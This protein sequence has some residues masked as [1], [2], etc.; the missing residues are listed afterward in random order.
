M[1]VSLKSESGFFFLRVL[2]VCI[3]DSAIDQVG[4]VKVLLV[5]GRC[6][7]DVADKLFL[8]SKGSNC[9]VTSDKILLDVTNV[10]MVKY[11]KP[12]PVGI[13]EPL[14]TDIS[15]VMQPSPSIPAQSVGA[16]LAGY[17]PR[18]ISMNDCSECLDKL[19]LPELPPDFCDIS[20]YKFIRN[21]TFQEEGCL[22]YPNLRMVTLVNTLETLFVPSLSKWFT[23]N[24]F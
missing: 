14:T 19:I 10:A 21:K 9:K 12:L 8:Q 16:Y 23:C 7:H 3:W 11:R 13:E 22:I 4:W 17:L 15:M 20:F 1:C 24:L 2:S 18:K 6:Q 5:S